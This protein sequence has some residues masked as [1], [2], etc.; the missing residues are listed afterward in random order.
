M[1][2]ACVSLMSAS[3]IASSEDAPK[4]PAVAATTESAAHSFRPGFDDMMTMLVQPRHLKLYYAG[5][6]KNWELAAAQL[7]GLR[8]ALGRIASSYPNYQDIGVDEALLS[9]IA[10]KLEAVA[11]A[12]ASADTKRFADAYRDLTSACNACHAYMER[13]F[14]VMKVPDA[15]GSGAYPNQEFGPTP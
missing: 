8:T 9:I 7:T 5:T 15:A 14:L 13:P 4:L 6:Q 12:I 3:K 10:P 1:V 11:I 2:V